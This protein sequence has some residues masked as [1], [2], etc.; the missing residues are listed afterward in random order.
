MNIF[1]SEDQL[2]D[3]KHEADPKLCVNDVR[4]TSICT[5]T[6]EKLQDGYRNAITVIYSCVLSQF[7]EQI[8]HIFDM[9]YIVQQTVQN[10]TM[11][12]HICSPVK[13]PVYQAR[14]YLS[15]VAN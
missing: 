13:V 4:I 2:N 11:H 15:C 7:K 8:E 12:N 9:I 5:V 6:T 14:P 10:D 3:T 1:D